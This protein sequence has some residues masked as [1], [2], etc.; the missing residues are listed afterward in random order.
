MTQQSKK[1]I[2]YIYLIAGAKAPSSTSGR[3]ER[4]G[5]GYSAV[6]IFHQYDTA[7]P[8]AHAIGSF[9]RIYPFHFNI[10]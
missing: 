2:K 7:G 6:I 10:Q 4:V 1:T 3:R 9:M 8:Q 5:R